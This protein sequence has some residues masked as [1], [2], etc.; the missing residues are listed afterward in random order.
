[1]YMGD[2]W[3]YHGNGSVGN[4]TYVWLP[5]VANGMGTLAMGCIVWPRWPL[6]RR[7]IWHEPLLFPDGWKERT[8]GGAGAEA[9]GVCSVRI[10][11]VHSHFP[12]RHV[13]LV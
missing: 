11:R 4:A 7:Q 2:R 8:Q 3:N 12:C 9:T 13:L 5:L 1:M 10:L 6:R